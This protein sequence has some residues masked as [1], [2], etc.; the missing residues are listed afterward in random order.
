MQRVGRAALGKE[1]FH[2]TTGEVASIS[3]D[4][5]LACPSALFCRKSPAWRAERGRSISRPAEAWSRR[6]SGVDVR[7][8]WSWAEGSKG[9][10][11]RSWDAEWGCHRGL[12][13]LLILSIKSI[14]SWMCEAGWCGFDPVAMLEFWRCIGPGASRE[15]LSRAYVVVPGLW[16]GVC[17]T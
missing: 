10:I 12:L 5:L 15:A 4:W 8:G 3:D 7:E 2:G 13:T 1:R 9:D 6:G 16:C 14:L 17:D 11:G